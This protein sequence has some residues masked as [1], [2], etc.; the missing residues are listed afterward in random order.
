MEP[1]GFFFHHDVVCAVS[2]ISFPRVKKQYH[3]ANWGLM[4]VR[5]C[6]YVCSCMVLI[7]CVRAFMRVYVLTRHP[8][9]SSVVL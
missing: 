3:M 9:R 7:V 1:F 8:A 5:S 4:G 6:I 2:I